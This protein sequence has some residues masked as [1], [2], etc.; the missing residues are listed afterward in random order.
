MRLQRWMVAIGL[1][2][3]LLPLQAQARCDLALVLALDISASI[4]SREYTLQ[5]DGMALAL[6][7]PEVI[8]AIED[9]GGIWLYGFEWSGTYQI[10]ETLPW[11]FVDSPD[12]II[13]A[14]ERMRAMP[15]PVS[16]Y[17]TALGYALGEAVIALNRAP[18]NCYRKI[19]D[20]AGDGINN[21]GF[22]PQSAYAAADMSGITVN[23][24]V[25]EG[26][27]PSPIP[28]FEAQVL[29]GPAAFVEVAQSYQDY[30]EAMTRKL[31]REISPASFV[32]L[33]P[34]LQPDYPRS[35][36]R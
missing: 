1:A 5:K 25:I 24:L 34:R 8:Q 17:P 27:L 20:V 28:Y 23:A 6:A 29:H 14:A 30:Q 13:G 11:V 15:R 36:R 32:M 10:Y 33:E 19:I 7:N 12:T 26:E 31:L 18:E 21:A 35:L 4:D 16:N 9:R 2:L 3:G 22:P